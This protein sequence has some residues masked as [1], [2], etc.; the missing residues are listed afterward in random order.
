MSFN[1]TQLL[2][3]YWEHEQ[4]GSQYI[5]STEKAQLLSTRSTGARQYR[6]EYVSA[7]VVLKH[8][9]LG[10]QKISEVQS[11][12]SNPELGWA[13]KYPQN[14]ILSRVAVKNLELLVYTV[15]AVP[16]E[17]QKKHDSSLFG[18]PKY[19]DPWHFSSNEKG[20]KTSHLVIFSKCNNSDISNPTVFAGG[21]NS[22]ECGTAR[23]SRA[24]RA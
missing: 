4:Y 21:A 8:E 14:S 15:R 9:I 19:H 24:D 16:N 22:G 23:P 5:V 3:V 7:V 18:M 13:R 11:P 2:R 10:V 20:R 12:E 17:K 1:K 6:E